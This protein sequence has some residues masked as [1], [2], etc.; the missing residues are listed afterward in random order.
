MRWWPTPRLGDECEMPAADPLATDLYE[1]LGV[2]SDASDNAIKKA[3]RA[4][5][6]VHHPDKGGEPESFKRLDLPTASL[7]ATLLHLCPAQPPSPWHAGVPKPMPSSQISN[8]V[9]HTTPRAMWRWQTSTS[10][11]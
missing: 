10:T 8:G 11:G 7:R 5:A 6:L 4:L 1:R 3:Y 2:P 9:A